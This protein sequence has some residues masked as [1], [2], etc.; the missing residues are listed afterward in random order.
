LASA[1]GVAEGAA[2]EGRNL[3]GDFQSAGFTYAPDRATLTSL[4]GSSTKL[5]GLF[6][7][8]NMNVSKDKIDGR[9]GVVPAGSTQSVVADYGFPDQPMLD[10]MTAA[11]LTV[12]KKNRDGFVLMV[13]GAS[14]DKQAHNMDSERWLLETIEFDKAIGV[15]K[16]FAKSNPET[17]VIVTADHE[18]A[19]VN[20]IGSSV[21]TNEQLLSRA[22]NA[23]AAT[24]V[25]KLRDQVVG[26]Y[27]AAG[28]PMYTMGADG[29]PVST[30][31]DYK[32]L[33][34]YAANSD[35][36]EDW[37]TN[38]RPLRDSSQPFNGSAPLNTYPNGPTNRD[39]AGN[40]FVTGQVPGGSAVHTGSD[41]PLTASGL[42]ASL[43]NG[44][45]DNTDVFFIAMQAA[46]GGV[47][48]GLQ[49]RQL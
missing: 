41:I 35:R 45:V 32:M 26:T 8:S 25:T 36:Y 49:G 44:I 46:L 3:L 13:E 21:L 14:I 17:L 24:G 9:R 19:G 40:F 30:D 37:L 39:T 23:D 34:G 29:Y 7:L 6:A 2:D 1:W 12:L 43:F 10:E 42:G 4:A 22:S 31:P 28:F 47:P 48:P 20:I 33:I 27:E 18:C 5:I 38:P 15:A 16:Q 11:A